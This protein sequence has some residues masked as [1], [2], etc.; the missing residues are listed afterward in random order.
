[1]V[2]RAK[3]RKAAAAMSNPPLAAPSRGPREHLI[4]W[5]M[6]ASLVIHGVLLSIHFRLPEKLARQKD[7]GLE[8]I[9]VNARHAR[10]PEKAEALAQAN[11][12]GGGNTDKDIRAKTPLPAQ[13]RRREGDALLEAQRRVQQLE[14]AQRE[15]LTRIKSKMPVAVDEQKQEQPETP[16]PVSGLDML[17]SAAAIARL[18]A[19]IDKDMVEY[20]KRPRRKFIGARTREYRFAQY[21]EDWRQ[22]IERV[23]TLNSPDAARG[24]VYGSLLLSVVIKADGS[25]D[26]IEVHRSSGH[27]VLDEAAQRIVRLAA[28]F[29]AFPPDIR[30]DTDI[31]EITRTWNFTS[32]DR[33]EAQ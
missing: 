33:V 7:R 9:L 16:K 26:S 18:E 32:A 10:A 20:A 29:A 11:L 4:L 14:A 27:K 24:R 2:S 8:V 17:D 23:G 19:Q 22:K 13:D 31:I 21:V 3:L 25:V 12:D 30:K 28:P 1:M 15:M 5:A 6:L